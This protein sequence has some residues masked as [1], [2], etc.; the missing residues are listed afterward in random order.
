MRDFSGRDRLNISLLQLYCCRSRDAI[1]KTPSETVVFGL[2]LFVVHVDATGWVVTRQ[3]NCGRDPVG[4]CNRDTQ[5]LVIPPID[6]DRALRGRDLSASIL[7][8]AGTGTDGRPRP[9]GFKR[10]DTEHEAW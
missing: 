6:R 9:T 10:L 1:D 4:Q 7:K 8:I 2:H 3:F 5:Y